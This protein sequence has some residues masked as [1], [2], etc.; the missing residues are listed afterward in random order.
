MNWVRKA[1]AELWGLFVDD[2]S[3]AGALIVWILLT[4]FLFARYFP[5]PWAGAVFFAG[6]A[7]I[8]IENTAR[9]ARN[10]RRQ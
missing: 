8:L 2:S 9:T 6:I 10:S 3:F 5:G 4:I 1:L 7:A